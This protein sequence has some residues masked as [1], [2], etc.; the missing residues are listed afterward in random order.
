M[1]SRLLDWHLLFMEY[2]LLVGGY[3]KLCSYEKKEEDD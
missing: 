2:Y 1:Y 3:L